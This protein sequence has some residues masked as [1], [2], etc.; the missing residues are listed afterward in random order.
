MECLTNSIEYGE[1]FIRLQRRLY[2]VT[3]AVFVFIRRQLWLR[4]SRGNCINCG[5]F[6]C[7]GAQNYETFIK[8]HRTNA[9]CNIT[10]STKAYAMLELYV[11]FQF[12]VSRTGGKSLKCLWFVAK[13]KK[14]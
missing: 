13:G 5:H 14:R 7:L 9:F 11:Y 1:L 12:L 4:S 6:A 10:T 8:R 3:L 2:Y